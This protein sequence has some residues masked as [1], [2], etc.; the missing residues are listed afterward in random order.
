MLCFARAMLEGIII[1]FFILA[2]ILSCDVTY[3]ALSRFYN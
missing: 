3:V 1:I 2:Y